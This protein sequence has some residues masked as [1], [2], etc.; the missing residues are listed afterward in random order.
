MREVTQMEVRPAVKEVW[1]VR[2]TI[3]E[4]GGNSSSPS[5]SYHFARFSSIVFQRMCVHVS[6]RHIKER[7]Y[8]PAARYKGPSQYRVKS[9]CSS[10]CCI[11]CRETGRWT[12]QTV[13]I[14]LAS[15]IHFFLTKTQYNNHNFENRSEPYFSKKSIVPDVFSP[16]EEIENSVLVRAV[17]RTN[18]L[19]DQI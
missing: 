9:G 17:Y 8:L 11:Q 12:D 4:K 18:L 16:W 10:K 6:L 2:Y 7:H 1:H 15:T 13:A 19:L 14:Q 5:L 3:V